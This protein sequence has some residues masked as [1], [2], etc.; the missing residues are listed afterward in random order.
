VLLAAHP[1]LGKGKLQ[2]ILREHE[3]AF[4]VKR[5]AVLEGQYHLAVFKL[6]RGAP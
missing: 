1:L 4:L 3:N 5:L 6:E 2:D